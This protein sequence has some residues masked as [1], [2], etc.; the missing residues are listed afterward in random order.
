VLKVACGESHSLALV[1]SGDLYAW[2][3]GYEG[4]LGIR[5]SIETVSIPKY[6]DSL[7][8][9]RIVEIACGS[10]HSLAIDENGDLY[11]WGEARCGQLGHGKQ[12]SQIFPTKVEL[13]D[14]VGNPMQARVK[15]VS[16]GY[17]HSACITEDL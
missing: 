13:C 12:R 14:D 7:F 10:R 6:I 4:Q 3:R 2:G 15:F 17:A 9:K 11:T 16:A 5:S 8:R 1:E